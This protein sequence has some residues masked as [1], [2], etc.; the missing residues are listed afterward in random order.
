M[1]SSDLRQPEQGVAGISTLFPN[2]AQNLASMTINAVTPTR[3]NVRMV[4]LLGQPVM[5]TKHQLSSG[6]NQLEWNVADL[7]PGL[8]LVEVASEDGKFL[9]TI[10][11]V[12]R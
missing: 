11:L 2:P 10:E 6:V 5:N 8:Y 12:K 4:N 7:A 3:V 9:Q 1:C